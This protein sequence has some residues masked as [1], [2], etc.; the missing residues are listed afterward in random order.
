MKN[1]KI[2]LLGL[3][4]LGFGTACKKNP[5]TTGTDVTTGTLIDYKNSPHQLSVGYYRTW[6]DSVTESGNATSMR[7]LPD[8]LDMVMVFPDYT[9]PENAYWNVLKTNY[10]PYL[11]TKG[12]KVIITIGDLNSATTTG[13][14]DSTG[15]AAW[16]KT[17]YDK[18]VTEYNL[19]GIDI[20]VE[21]NPTGTTL[22]KKVAAVKAL[23]KYFGPRSGTGKKFIYDTNQNPTTFF[24]SIYKLIDYTFLQAYGRSTSNLTSTF[25][26]YAAYITPDKFLPGFS[27]YEENGASWGDVQYPDATLQSRCYQYARWQ[28]TQGTKG[29][30]FSYAIDRDVPYITNSIIAA[31]YAVTK[32]L[33]KIMNP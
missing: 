29:G 14:Q 25:N 17:I 21:S 22:T 11:H 23:S 28:P 19:D 24:T 20:D 27:F 1:F 10:V 4:L 31:D 2:C 30:V 13:G 15:Y 16:A 8:S 6:R 3:A 9:P 7:R 12:T 26:L 33:I 18:W 5:P 32:K